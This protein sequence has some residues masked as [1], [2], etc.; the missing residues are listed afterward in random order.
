MILQ[1]NLEEANSEPEATDIQK[2]EMTF[3]NKEK[4]DQLYL[5]FPPNQKHPHNN[6]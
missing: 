2:L 4:A 6:K 1:I 3:L 5:V